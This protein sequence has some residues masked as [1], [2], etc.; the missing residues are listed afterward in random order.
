MEDQNACAVVDPLLHIYPVLDRLKMQHILLGLED[1]TAAGRK[2][3]GACFLKVLQSSHF[4]IFLIFFLL[5]IWRS[6]SWDPSNKSFL[7][8]LHYSITW[9]NSS[10]RR[11]LISEFLIC[12][13]TAIT[14]RIWLKT[15]QELG[16]LF[17]ALWNLRLPV[18]SLML[19]AWYMFHNFLLV[20]VSH[21]FCSSFTAKQKSNSSFS[22]DS[23]RPLSSVLRILRIW[24]LLFLPLSK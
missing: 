22:C 20:L 4:I 24:T 17:H 2:I 13:L 14:N 15:C 19:T 21:I 12:R 16:S 7:G 18:V 1:L 6:F 9:C 5:Q 8:L 11:K 10:I 23:L 3:R